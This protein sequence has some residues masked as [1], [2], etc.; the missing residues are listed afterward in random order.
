[1][2]E[3]DL[4]NPPEDIQSARDADIPFS[5]GLRAAKQEDLNFILSSWL[6]S[7]RDAKRT[8]KNHDYF[9]GQQ[10]L[11]AAL[12]DRRSL[13]IG[14][15]VDKPDWIVGY[16]CG[17]KLEDGSLLLDYVY[18]KQP[19]RERGIGKAL[20]AA[21][22]WAPDTHIVATHWNR[23]AHALCKK[24]MVDHNEYYLMIGGN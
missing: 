15:D 20:I 8:M 22:G 17:Q 4:I 21:L 10:K 18:V 9:T 7:Y 24:F 5:L 1:M 23:V 19:Y 16:A 11:I 6:R 2:S 14:C 13:V 3:L 12:A